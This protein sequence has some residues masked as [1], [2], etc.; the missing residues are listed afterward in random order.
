[1][2]ERRAVSSEPV[3]RIV[4]S[5]SSPPRAAAVRALRLLLG[6]ALVCLGGAACIERAPTPASKRARFDRAPVR[7]LLLKDLPATALHVGAIFGEA[8]ELSAIDYFPRR[9]SAGDTVEVTF[10][11]R[12]QRPPEVNYKVFVHG[13]ARGAEGRINADHW[14][15]ERRYG[16][17]VWQAGELVRDRFSL[18]IPRGF[19]GDGV[20]LW[21]GFYRP[22]Q[23]EVRWSLTAVGAGATDGKN[24]LRVATIPVVERRG[25]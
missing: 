3:R 5:P 19:E 24:R 20:N 4:A 23:A 13:E 8:V 6:L 10:F 22:Q 15:A 11:W 17:D 7:E 14:P 2:K 21:T 1:M 12:V 16:T 9:P 18:K 25:R